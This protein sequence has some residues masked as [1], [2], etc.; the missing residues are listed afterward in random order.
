MTFS[1][2]LS[3]VAENV[4]KQAL[5]SSN[6]IDASGSVYVSRGRTTGKAT[7]PSVTVY[8]QNETQWIWNVPDIKQVELNIE[9]E[10]RINEQNKEDGLGSIV[11]DALE[12]PTQLQV[13]GSGSIFI[14]KYNTSEGDETDAVEDQANTWQQRKQIILVGGIQ[15]T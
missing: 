14:L 4:V 5:S 13:S 2:R 11:F 9:V 8:A 6:Y 10:Q 1:Q 7:V 15:P 3:I 12:L